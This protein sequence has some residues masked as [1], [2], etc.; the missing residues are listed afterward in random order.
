MTARS[1]LSALDETKWPAGAA[2]VEYFGN[3]YELCGVGVYD[4]PATL[5]YTPV[6]RRCIGCSCRR[7]HESYGTLVLTDARKVVSGQ[8]ITAAFLRPLTPL[9]REMLRTLQ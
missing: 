3:A 9:A 8:P 6:C 2:L 7:L 4:T 5:P 1:T